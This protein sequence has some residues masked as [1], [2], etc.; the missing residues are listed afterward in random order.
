MC[1]KL[2]DCTEE[3]CVSNCHCTAHFACRITYG[4]IV[5]LHIS[6]CLATLTAG[7]YCYEQNE[8][9]FLCIVGYILYVSLMFVF[10]VHFSIYMYRYIGQY[11]GEW[12]IVTANY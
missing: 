7:R 10:I 12:L 8:I 11:N 6:S 2:H 1:T 3:V 9:S 5:E 4:L